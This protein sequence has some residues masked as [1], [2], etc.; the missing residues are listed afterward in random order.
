[1]TLETFDGN[2]KKAY[3]Q[4]QPGSMLH[5]DQ[6]TNERRLNPITESGEDLRGQ[7]FYTADGNLYTV[8]QGEVLWGITRE[9]QNLILQNIGEASH[10]LTKNGN[11]F[12]NAEEAASSFDHLDTVKVDV[13]GLELREMEYTQEY[14]FFVINP[15]KVKEL[16]DEQKLAATRIFGPD[17]NNFGQ[18]MEMFSRVDKSPY[19]LVLMPDYVGNVLK[20]NNK[21]YLARASRLGSYSNPNFYAY[22]SELDFHHRIRGVR[23]KS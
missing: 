15:G 20:N 19:I 12:P 11:Y 9:P 6:L 10:R 22:D 18:N 4:I 14:G 3:A 13:W 23:K 2:L 5:V 7:Y 8:R 21:E 1:M 16:N 17:E